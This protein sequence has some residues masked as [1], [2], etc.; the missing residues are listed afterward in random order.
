VIQAHYQN[1]ET[2]VLPSTPKKPPTATVITQPESDITTTEADDDMPGFLLAAKKSSVSLASKE[3]KNV[4]VS[5]E[6]E[7]LHV[8]DVGSFYQRLTQNT[9]CLQIALFLI[10][11]ISLLP[12]LF[13]SLPMMKPS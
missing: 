12:M 13:L 7:L 9:K 5:P 1:L 6:F 10:E 8:H 2:A 11:F 4:P 3:R